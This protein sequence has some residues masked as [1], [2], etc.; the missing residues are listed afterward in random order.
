MKQQGTPSSSG[1]G[2]AERRR[3]WSAEEAPEQEAVVTTET[4]RAGEKREPIAA[5]ELPPELKGRVKGLIY[6]L[7]NDDLPMALLDLAHLY[8]A[9]RTGSSRRSRVDEPV[10]LTADLRTLI[11][12]DDRDAIEEICLGPDEHGRCPRAVEGHPVDCAD[13]WIMN[14]GWNFK[15][16]PD[17]ETCPL[18]SLGLAH[19]Y[20]RAAIVGRK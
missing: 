11:F 7:S 2:A 15:V 12:N 20:L 19:R 18:V 5:D 4:R 6:D 9:L 10:E 8:R 1:D 3:P 14:K 16:A 17:A 13:K